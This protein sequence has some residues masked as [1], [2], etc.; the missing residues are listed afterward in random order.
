MYTTL[1]DKANAKAHLQV[2]ISPRRVVL[3]RSITPV[4]HL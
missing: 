2:I 3:I 1:P 4:Q